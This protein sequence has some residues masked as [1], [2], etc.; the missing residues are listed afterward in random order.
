MVS[1]HIHTAP[2]ANCI[3]DL[4]LNAID[5]FTDLD[6]LG[7]G[8]TRPYVDKKYFFQELKNPPKKVL[9]DLSGISATSNNSTSLDLSNTI[10]GLLQKMDIFDEANTV[11]GAGVDNILTTTPTVKTTNAF[12]QSFQQLQAQQSQLLPC[13]SSSSTSNQVTT[14]TLTGIIGSSAQEL[15]SIPVSNT[16]K[17]TSTCANF[18]NTSLISNTST[19]TSTITTKPTKL[20][21]PSSVTSVTLPTNFNLNNYNL[22][23]GPT[24]TGTGGDSTGGT[25]DP[26][27]LPRDTDPFSPTRKKSDPFQ[28][29][30]IF[31]NLDPFEF[32]FSASNESAAATTHQQSKQQRSTPVLDSGTSRKTTTDVFNGPLQVSLPPESGVQPSAQQWK[33][34]NETT[35]GNNVARSRP[36]AVLAP[37]QLQSN[38]SSAF[39]QQTADVISSISNK[40]M[41]HLFGQARFSKRDSNSI[42]MR[43][44]QE[45]DSLSENESAPEPPPRPDSVSHVEPPPLPPKKQ[46]SDIVIRPRGITVSS[47]SVTMST[48]SAT[49]TAVSSAT[50]NR[51]EFLNSGL[52]LSS[53][54]RAGSAGVD[55]PPIPLPSRRVGRSDGMYP[56]P[57]R[58]RKP[59]HT[60][61]DYLAP[62]SST[63]VAA[64]SS[65]SGSSSLPPSDV[66]PLLPPPTQTSTRAR[67]QRQL[68]LQQGKSQ[69]IYENKTEIIREQQQ[70]A[71][72]TVGLA[73]A[74]LPD[75][76]LSQLLTLG[77]DELATKLNVPTS[78]LSTMTLVELTSYLSEFLEKSKPQ[79]QQV[80]FASQKNRDAEASKQPE[81]DE[82]VIFKVN[83]D[84]EATFVAKFDD[85]F[86][87]VQHDAFVANFEQFNEHAQQHV[88]QKSSSS[89]KRRTP[90][91]PPADRYA[92][93]REIIDQEMQQ[94]QEDTDLLGDMLTD[95]NVDTEA[96]TSVKESTME[97]T[98]GQ[99]SN[100]SFGAHFND[101]DDL[102]SNPLQQKPPNRID[103]KITEVIA[104]AKDRYA[105]LRDIIL[106]ENLFDK[107]PTS[108]GEQQI[109]QQ[110]HVDLMSVDADFPEFGDEDQD[111]KQIM[112]NDRG[113]SRGFPAEASSSALTVGDDDDEEE[114]GIAESSLDSN[115]KDGGL[116]SGGGKELAQ[117][118]YEKLSTSTQQLDGKDEKSERSN[119]LITSKQDSKFLTVAGNSGLSSS[120]DDLEI[121]EL[122]QR[123][124]SNLSL[125]S[126][127]R[128]SPATAPVTVTLTSDSVTRPID[129]SPAFVTTKSQFNDV[130][131]SP[132]PLQKSPSTVQQQQ[133]SQLLRKSPE[134]SSIPAQ[135]TAVSH[136]I[137][138]ASRQ[139]SV[140]QG[141]SV[142]S[143]ESWAT[144][145]SPKTQS[146][147]STSAEKHRTHKRDRRSKSPKAITLHIPP[148]PPSNASQNDT[149]ESPCSSDPRDERWSKN[150]RRWPKADR[151][152]GTGN[153]FHS[154]I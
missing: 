115:D 107:Q 101:H 12:D 38:A 88:S 136:L 132:I 14:N 89:A 30:D 56:G 42:N 93:F 34:L 124:I 33:P 96:G 150:V 137:N 118:Q 10:E 59:G 20:Q 3:T 23:S 135:L 116:T 47:S 114:D 129:S 110:Q 68:S 5:A 67:T 142:H 19:T 63:S 32:E 64:V 9:K 106:V 133:K 138:T 52:K 36:N 82:P 143:K 58:P 109:D 105:A 77:I 39:K 11:A 54:T 1:N 151:G 40:K 92:V 29:G 100:S 91:V 81:M 147:M 41:P 127:E 74:I 78:K 98:Q 6:P 22:E 140:D 99:D 2:L 66:P 97:L 119:N 139:I 128:S 69:E 103:T 144:F 44:L 18:T 55:V 71:E 112:E 79:Q 73:P 152:G 8:R 28:E 90:A 126:R 7:T 35:V 123:A 72:E 149:A 76:T 31:A 15:I 95:E 141:S 104:Q 83:F 21:F 108:I 16:A 4:C 125:D 51:Y 146:Y 121:D 122:M 37:G 45:S 120:K 61:D 43:R 86:G 134:T 57:G 25:G 70:R 53:N 60:E 65:S 87:E 50:A 117:D 49:T 26:V 75:I 153:I 113:S 102:L 27:M 148:P 145:D 48:T 154:K 94:R 85:N 13:T 62:I 80:Q 46:F 84:Q 131:T 111:L 130:S 24:G 17:I